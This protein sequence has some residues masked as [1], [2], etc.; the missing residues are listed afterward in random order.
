MT[1]EFWMRKMLPFLIPIEAMKKVGEDAYEVK[2]KLQMIFLFEGGVKVSGEKNKVSIHFNDPDLL[3]LMTGP[4]P[5][6]IYRIPYQRLIGF[7]LVN[8]SKK[9]EDSFQFFRN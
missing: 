6:K 8:E 1:R 4:N 7:E 5:V 3:I 9:M 2:K